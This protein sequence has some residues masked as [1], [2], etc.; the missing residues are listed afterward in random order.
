MLNKGYLFTAALTLLATS[1]SVQAEDKAEAAFSNELIQCAAYYQI[2]SSMIMGMNA[3]QMK[4]VGERLKTSAIEA[5]KIA[6]SYLPAEQV[7]ADIATAKEQQLASLN[8]KGNLGPLMGKYKEV[9]KKAVLDPKA[10]LDYWAM[11]MM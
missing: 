8:G 10:R 9:C 5:E 7:V 2:S 6:G 4:P 1:L 11:V 3:P